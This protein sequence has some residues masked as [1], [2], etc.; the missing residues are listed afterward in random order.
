MLGFLFGNYVN[1]NSRGSKK[2]RNVCS[3]AEGCLLINFQINASLNC[4]RGLRTSLPF[5]GGSQ[6]EAKG[7]ALFSQG[8]GDRGKT[9]FEN[10]RQFPEF[11]S[12]LRHKRSTMS[13][14]KL[15]SLPTFQKYFAKRSNSLCLSTMGQGCHGDK[16][17]TNEIIPRYMAPLFWALHVCV[18]LLGCVF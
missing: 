1:C 8:N 11:S 13:L 18:S 6:I 12:L 9:T 14:E 15:Q 2:L 5:A 16:S 10:V 3:K 4:L 17:L 7:V